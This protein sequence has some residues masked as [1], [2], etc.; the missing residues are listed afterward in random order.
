[1][2]LAADNSTEIVLDTPWFKIEAEHCVEKASLD[3][4]PLVRLNAP[5]GA[6]AF[7]ISA[8]NLDTI[9]T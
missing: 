1:M 9:T 3:R 2:I 6:M 5:H 8:E 4:K 7:V